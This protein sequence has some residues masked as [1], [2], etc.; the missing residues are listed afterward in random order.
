[1]DAWH[2]QLMLESIVN[3]QSDAGA[4]LLPASGPV[5]AEDNQVQPGPD[6]SQL[7]EAF[8]TDMNHYLTDV[9]KEYYPD[10]YRMYFAQALRGEAFK[11]G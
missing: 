6:R 3:Y 2:H 11:K 10:N 8:Q 5:K 1:V 7:V 4:E 9:A